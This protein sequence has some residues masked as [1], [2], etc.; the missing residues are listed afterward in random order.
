MAALWKMFC[1]EQKGNHVGSSS[2]QEM[3][4]FRLGGSSR[5][6]EKSLISARFSE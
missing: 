1:G 5:D 2:C 4:W 6:I 3:L